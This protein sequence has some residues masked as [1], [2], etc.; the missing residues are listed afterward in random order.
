VLNSVLFFQKNSVLLTFINNNW[1][2][3]KS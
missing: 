1:S 2:I 3:T